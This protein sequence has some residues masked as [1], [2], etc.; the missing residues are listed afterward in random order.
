MIFKVNKAIVILSLPAVR[1]S[2]YYV[3]N[4]ELWIGLVV[5]LGLELVKLLQSSFVD[6]VLN[7]IGR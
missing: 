4:C 7:N 3:Y 1:N 2:V 6:F 5:G